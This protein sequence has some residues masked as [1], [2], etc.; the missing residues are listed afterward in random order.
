METS[1]GAGTSC[2]VSDDYGDRPA[3]N[4]V[5]VHDFQATILR[6]TGLDHTR[7]TYRY[8]GRDFRL[9]DVHGKVIEDVI[10]WDAGLGRDSG[11]AAWGHRLSFLFD[12]QW[13]E[14]RWA[15][16]RFQHSFEFLR[17]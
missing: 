17:S 10:T 7:L 5:H 11:V 6:R 2:G 3:E 8:S 13:R 9:T 12:W 4:P 14:M 1:P 16:L 15:V